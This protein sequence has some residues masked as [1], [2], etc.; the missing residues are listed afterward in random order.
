L[1]QDSERGYCLVC[2]DVPKAPCD[3]CYERNVLIDDKCIRCYTLF[4]KCDKCSKN[5]CLKCY[6][7]YGFLYEEGCTSFKELFGEGYLS[8][9]LNPYDGK[10]YCAECQ[11]GYFYGTDGKCKTCQEDGNLANCKKYQELGKMDI[12]VLLVKII[13]NY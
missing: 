3:L 4:D 12:F 2:S 7:G 8:C 9:G 11:Y 5:Q 13:M 10:P 6:S 1:K